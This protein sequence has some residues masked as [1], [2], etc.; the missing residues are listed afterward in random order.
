MIHLENL[1]KKY[2]ATLAVDNIS[3]DVEKGEIVG[4]LGPNGAGKTTTMKIL[5]CYMPPTSGT[6]TVAGLD[7]HESSLE[8]R[9]NVGYLPEMNPLYFEMSAYEWLEFIARIHNIDENEIIN[10]IRKVAGAC[11]LSDVLMKDI[12]EL[13]KGY[14][15]RVGFA[16]T[17][18]HDPQ[19]L[20]LDEPTAGLDP[21][22]A[23]EI[24][25]LIRELGK[26]KTVILSTHIL[27]EVQVTCDR[28]LIINK[29]KI[30]ADGTTDELQGMVQGKET[31]WVK[32]KAPKD[33]VI[34]ELPSLEGVETVNEK[35]SEDE[36]ITGYELK[37]ASGVDLRESV[38]NFAVKHKWVVLEMQRKPVSLEDIFRTLTTETGKAESA[39]DNAEDNGKAGEPDE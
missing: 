34:D 2:D 29:G 14:R 19:I 36:N 39:A 10:R 11:G 31:L 13:S 16:Q 15:Q 12:G 33:R 26:E 17:I 4:F 37:A 6:A 35:E 20:I 23:D 27:S 32:I 25:K 5:T 28:V 21:N 1:T 22:Q 30:V 18:L 3:F 9:K 38:F 7:I 8:I 24:R